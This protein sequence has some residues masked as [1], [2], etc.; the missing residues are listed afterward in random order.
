MQ[1]KTEN[2]ETL[3]FADIHRLHV[4]VVDVVVVDVAVVVAVVNVG[5]A[6]FGVEIVSD[7]VR[8]PPM[9]MRTAVRSSLNDIAGTRSASPANAAPTTAAAADVIIVAEIISL[10]QT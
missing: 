6:V 10:I 3:T 4:S 9:T 8:R 7:M 2:R 1:A 5:G